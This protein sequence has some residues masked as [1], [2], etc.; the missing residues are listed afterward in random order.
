MTKQI[1]KN[2]SGHTESQTLLK[3]DVTCFLDLGLFLISAFN[4]CTNLKTSR[5]PKPH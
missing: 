3:C 4:I 2:N 5:N 1:M